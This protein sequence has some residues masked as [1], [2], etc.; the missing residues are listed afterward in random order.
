MNYCTVTTLF[1]SL[2]LHDF[3]KWKTQNQNNSCPP[4]RLAIVTSHKK[5]SSSAKNACIPLVICFS[6]DLLSTPAKVWDNSASIKGTVLQWCTL[7]L[8]LKHILQ[9]TKQGAIKRN[10]LHGRNCIC[11]LLLYIL[12]GDFHFLNIKCNS[13]HWS[14][15]EPSCTAEQTRLTKLPLISIYK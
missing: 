7:H 6:Q 14:A 13:H 5:Q 11:Q 15:G 1:L 3:Y 2:Y 9:D 8:T 10:T 12:Q 4:S